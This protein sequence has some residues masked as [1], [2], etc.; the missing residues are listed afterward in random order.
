MSSAVDVSFS[1]NY[2]DA[3]NLS[4]GEEL[5][6]RPTHTAKFFTS[7]YLEK[8]RAGATVW[9][10]YHSKKLWVSKSNTG[11]Q[12]SEAEYAPSRTTINLNLFKKIGNDIEGFV[13]FE[14]IFDDV[15]VDFGYWPGF[16]VF[17]GFKYGFTTN[18]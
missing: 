9:G 3:R 6:N 16:Q 10:N 17:L 11:E 12:E 5:L 7:A 8:W 1:Y 13:R 14:N 2:L 15:N 4:T 18:R